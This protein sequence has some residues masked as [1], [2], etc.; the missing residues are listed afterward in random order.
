MKFGRHSARMLWL[1]LVA[2]V[3]LAV[4]APS[5]A[6]ADEQRVARLGLAISA[7]VTS[8]QPDLVNNEIDAVNKLPPHPLV[9]DLGKISAAPFFQAEGRFFVSDR[10]VAVAGVGKIRKTSEVLVTPTGSEI[11]QQGRIQGVLR[12]LGADYYFTPYTR[13]DF[14]V[15]PFAGGGYMDVTDARSKVGLQTT[16][17][18]TTTGG[19][20]RTRGAGPG[21][22]AEAGAHLMLPSRYS[23]IIDVN[24]HHV[25]A[26]DLRFEDA[27]G[28][29]NG[30]VL[31]AD[32]KPAKLDFSGFGLRFAVNIN[33][34][35]RF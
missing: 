8:L 20:V 10:I 18:S 19:F 24:Y 4:L 31:D 35:N 23:F 32:G 22:Y 11:L 33:I 28:N 16:T 25:Q 27:H 34:K 29:L 2:L 3:L 13:G 6:R 30:L 12:H 1:P 7:M 5:P 9:V 17:G 26:T 21:F 14:T 15:R